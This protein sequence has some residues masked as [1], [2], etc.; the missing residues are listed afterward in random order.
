MLLFSDLL[1]SI[2]R[3]RSGGPNPSTNF[4]FLILI[5]NLALAIAGMNKKVGLLDADIFGPSIPKLMNLSGEPELTGSG[6]IRE[7]EEKL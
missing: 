7:I 2:L 4:I 5:V 1:L 3:H 6:N